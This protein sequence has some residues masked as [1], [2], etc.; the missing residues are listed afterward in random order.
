[1]IDEILLK[2]YFDL[3]ERN[4]PDAFRIKQVRDLLITELTDELWLVVASDSAGGIGPKM[5]DSYF[6]TGYE[7]GRLV[8]RVPIMETLASGAMPITVIDALAVEMEPTGKEIIRGVKDESADAGL[9]SDLAVTGSTEDNV[10]TVQTGMGA[11]VIGF[12]HKND[13]KPGRSVA[14]DIVVCV[15]IPKSAPEFKVVYSDEEITNPQTIRELNKLKYVHDILPVGSKGIKHE[16][17]ELAK[18]AGLE[19]C[20]S[21]YLSVNISKSGGPSTCCLVSI[22]P[23]KL[24]ELIE[25]INCPISSIGELRKTNI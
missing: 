1:M 16:F 20:Y 12:V 10:K 17:N 5:N 3:K 18:S 11:V 2:K 21:D 8:V 24:D 4:I 19:A 9:K 14:G 25:K 13:F 23:D 15:G 6:A 7:L 22:P